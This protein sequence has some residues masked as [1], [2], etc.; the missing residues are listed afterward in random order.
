MPAHLDVGHP[1]VVEVAGGCEPLSAGA[2]LVRLLPAV[3]PP[4]GVEGGRGGEA[5]VADVADVRPLPGVGARVAVEQAGAVKALAAEAAREHF[6]ALLVVRGGGLWRG[7]RDGDG[8]RSRSGP[9]AAPIDAAS[10]LPIIVVVDGGCHA[11]ASRAGRSV[12]RGHGGGRGQH[13]WRRKRLLLLLLS[14]VIEAIFPA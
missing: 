7:L 11:V 14:L 2:A 12:R 10:A 4:V 13:R 3:D 9:A 8:D 6:L 1:V 5:L